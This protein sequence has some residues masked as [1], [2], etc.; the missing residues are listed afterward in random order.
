MFDMG[1]SIVSFDGKLLV[2]LVYSLCHCY[3]FQAITPH[4]AGIRGPFLGGGGSP[5][6]MGRSK[7]RVLLYTYYYS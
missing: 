1:A 4:M 5:S 6:K 2:F 3:C 7:A